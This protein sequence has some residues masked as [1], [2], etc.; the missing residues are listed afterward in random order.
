MWEHERNSYI[1]DPIIGVPAVA[2]WVMNP[3]S[4]ARVTEKARVVSPF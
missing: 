4:G 2:Q 1:K 3:T